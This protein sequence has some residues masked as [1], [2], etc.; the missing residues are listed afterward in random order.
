MVCFFAPTQV[1]VQ[2]GCWLPFCCTSCPKCEQ[3]GGVP[4]VGAVEEPTVTTAGTDAGGKTAAA[5]N[6]E[7]ASEA[8]AARLAKRVE[9][10]GRIAPMTEDEAAEKIAKRKAKF[11][12]SDE[13]IVLFVY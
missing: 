2:I 3:P 5:T 13:V 12:L 6:G 11:G 7:A 9:R 4:E 10:F 8:E 1:Y